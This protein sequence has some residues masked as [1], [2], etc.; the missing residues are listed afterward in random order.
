MEENV[1]TILIDLAKGEEK[2]LVNQV[3]YFKGHYDSL[4]EL[5]CEHLATLTKYKHNDATKRLKT[6][7]ANN[8]ELLA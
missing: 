7:R 3:N 4:I 6:F 2:Y 1:T 5:K 8:N